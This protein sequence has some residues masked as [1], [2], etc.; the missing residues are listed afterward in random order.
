MRLPKKPKPQVFR[1]H[2][3]KVEPPPGRRQLETRTCIECKTSWCEPEAWRWDV[4]WVDGVGLV[5]TCSK[6]CRAKRGLKERREVE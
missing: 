3:K 1:K 2:P 6:A 5:D 4:H